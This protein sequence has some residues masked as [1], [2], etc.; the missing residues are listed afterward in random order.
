MRYRLTLIASL[1]PLL[2][3][4]FASEAAEKSEMPAFKEGN[5]ILFQGDSITD[6]N[7]GCII[8]TR[9]TTLLDELLPG[10]AESERGHAFVPRKA[11]SQRVHLAKRDAGCSRAGRNHGKGAHSLSR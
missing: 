2:G 4:V 7:R 10:D 5:V 11:K 8:G 1:I 6:M 9:S 3:G